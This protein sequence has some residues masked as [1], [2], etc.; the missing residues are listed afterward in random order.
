MHLTFKKV[1][2]MWKRLSHRGTIAAL[3]MLLLGI[4]ALPASSQGNY[5]ILSN[6]SGVTSS[7]WEIQGEPTLVMNGFDI[8]PTSLRLPVVVDNINID[9]FAAG[10][11]QLTEVV[12]YEDPNG[13]SPVDAQL[14]AST[15]PVINT[16]GVFNVSF[17]SPVVVNSPI[18]W[19][20]FYMPPGVRFRA[21]RQGSSVLTYWAWTPDGTFD[22]TDLSTA[23]VFG[24]SDGSDPVN[25]DLNGIAR[26]RAE[27]VTANTQ[28]TETFFA[29][30]DLLLP[31][32]PLDLLLNYD[33]CPTLFK[34]ETDI[35]VTYDNTISVTC[36]EVESWN[37]PRAP[38]GYT[39]RTNVRNIVY[40][41]AFYDDEGNVLPN[42]LPHPVTHCVTPALEE[43]P[44]AV[45][46][47]AYGNPR[48]WEFLTSERYNNLVCAE[49][50]RGGS[51]S[52]FTPN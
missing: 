48:R 14:V 12:V 11:N 15:Q 35:T 20:G 6:N 16:T 36:R 18:I 33:G 51:L 7:L 30:Q 50:P 31:A 47:I 37:A 27:A 32:D 24:P 10:P 42:E 39:R 44:E 22:L 52:Y 45:I 26:I 23:Q 40:D 21:D 8:T 34:D 38:S 3:M 9:I 41:L 1:D 5:I 46:G 29:D 4:S 19:V 17:P 2:A 28:T 25:I 49:V 43:Q 13:G